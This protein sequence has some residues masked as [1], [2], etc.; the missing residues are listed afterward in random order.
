MNIGETIK[1][2]RKEKGLTQKE[3]GEKCG[4]AESTLRQYELGI[5]KPKMNT[6]GKIANALEIPR[7][8]YIVK[9]NELSFIMEI[10]NNSNKDFEKRMLTYLSALNSLGRKELEKKMLEL[11]NNPKYQLHIEE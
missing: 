11:I 3:L 6:I 5:R 1:K 9:T 10:S 2:Y 7:I 4:I 8:D